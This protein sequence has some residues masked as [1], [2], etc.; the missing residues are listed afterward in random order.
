MALPVEF[1]VVV[2]LDLAVLARRDARGGAALGQGGPEPVAVI[3]LVAEQFLGV[4]QCFKQQKSAVVITHLPF[5]QEHHDGPPESIAHGM[6][7]RVQA[8]FAGLF[9]PT[10]GSANKLRS[11]PGMK[12]ALFALAVAMSELLPVSRTPS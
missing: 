1:F 12:L 11:V 8:P 4:G 6:K 2:V 9:G 10:A 3:T 7:L 5:G